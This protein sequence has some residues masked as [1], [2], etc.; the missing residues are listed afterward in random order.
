MFRKSMLAGA[1]ALAILGFAVSAQAVSL[2]DLTVE[3]KPGEPLEAL[4]EINDLDLTISPLL[5]RVAPP[6]TYLREGVNWPS[7]VQ[8]LKLARDGS[9]GTV[10]LRLYGEQALQSGSFPLLMEMNAGGTVTVRAYEVQ[11]KDGSFVVTPSAE[12]TTVKGEP[13]RL[14]PEPLVVPREPEAAQDNQEAKKEGKAETKSESKAESGAAALAVKTAAASQK[15]VSAA[16]AEKQGKIR[17]KGRYAPNVVKEYVALNGFDASQAFHVQQDMTLWSVALLYWPSYRGATLE[18]LVIAFRNLNRTAFKEGDP[19]RLEVRSVL[20]PP[21]VE[22]VLAIDPVAAFHEVHGADTAIPGPTQN[23]IDAQRLSGEAAAKVADAQDRERTAGKAPEVVAEAGQQALEE[24]KAEAVREEAEAAE[25]RAEAK[26]AEEAA[27]K[28]AAAEAAAA[29]KPAES[30]KP[31]EPAADAPKVEPVKTEAPARPADAAGS[32]GTNNLLFWGVGAL[33]LAL[34]AFLGLRSRKREEDPVEEKKPVAVQIQK[35]VPPTSEAQLK[36][37]ST[38]VD[39]AVKNGT[40]AG[41]MGAGA[42]AY[43]MA[44]KNET[45]NSE[46]ALKSE[47][48]G[49]PADQPWLE[50]DDDELPPLDEEEK[51]PVLGASRQAAAV[52]E[53][54]SLELDDAVAPAQTSAPAAAPAAATPAPAEQK[55]AEQPEPAEP[56]TDKERA[57]A[58]ALDAKLKLATSF[59]SLGAVDEALELLQEVK[60]RGGDELRHRAEVLEERI[61]TQTD[62]K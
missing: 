6:A 5:V 7:Q 57:L 28:A 3:S 55:P 24:E 44:Q 58:K 8:D 56:E 20:N 21:T 4:L 48:T 37:V 26:A 40:T 2:G 10:R 60:R 32:G 61:K 52:L 62:P 45:R 16:S 17:R 9:N 18:Q 11:T 15:E 49:A 53:G 36:A 38:T 35:D 33:V 39:E 19:G 13:R 23:L 42:M 51:G 50:P 47:G 1:T 25:A 43:A 31:A 14:S 12:R 30:A 59:V 27:E 29:E 22:E 46:K 34:L 54:V 41:A